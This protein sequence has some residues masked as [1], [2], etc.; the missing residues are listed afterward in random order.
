MICINNNELI[1]S[2]N[3][4]S[5]SN[6]WCLFLEILPWDHVCHVYTVTL[7]VLWNIFH[8]WRVYKFYQIKLCTNFTLKSHKFL[9]FTKNKIKNFC[10]NFTKT[11]YEFYQDSVQIVQKNCVQILLCT[12][13]PRTSIEPY[14]MIMSQ[15]FKIKLQSPMWLGSI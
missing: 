6:S 3:C 11:V 1:M 10:T 7:L 15:Q 8:F 4:R 12:N 13:W 2:F 5:F 14:N 9:T